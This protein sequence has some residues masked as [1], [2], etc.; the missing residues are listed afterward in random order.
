M[1]LTTAGLLGALLIAAPVG[2]EYA[3]EEDAYRAASQHFQSVNATAAFF[4]EKIEFG[5]RHTLIIG[6]TASGELHYQRAVQREEKWRL[7][8][9]TRFLVKGRYKYRCI[10]T[11]KQVIDAYLIR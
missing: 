7:S 4:C 6:K 9:P 5:V 11:K 10:D 1:S 3:T 8:T 2:V